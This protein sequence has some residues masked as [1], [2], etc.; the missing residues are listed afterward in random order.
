[1][2]EACW[3]TLTTKLYWDSAV[4]LAWLQGEDGREAACRDT[5]DAAQRGEDL[6]VTSALTLAEVLWL[7]GGPRLT[8][9]KA[10]RL[11]RFFRRSFIRVV[12]VDRRIAEG[13]QQLVWQSGIKPKD[14]IHVSSALKYQCPILE[15]FDGKLIRKG[16]DLEAL[17]VR[18][19]QEASRGRGE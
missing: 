13:A 8:E 10:D 19:P 16:L 2:F 7:K 5:L 15:T 12:N 14:S 1:M 3:L 17:E 18:E 9:E 11:N 6:I 4:F